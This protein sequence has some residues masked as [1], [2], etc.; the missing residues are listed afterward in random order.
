MSV[1]VTGGTGTVGL[2]IVERLAARGPVTVYASPAPPPLVAAALAAMPGEVHVVEGD[3]RD[4]DR[5]REVL[6]ERRIEA[7]VHGAAITPG[8]ERERTD[9][10]GV[11]DVNVVGAVT[12]LGAFADA[13]SGRY[14]HLGSIAAYGAAAATEPLLVEETGQERPENLYEITKLAG[15]QAVLRVAGLR[16]VDAVSLRLGDVFGRW[17][18]RSSAR[19][20]TS[21]PFQT[22]AAALEGVEAVLPRE[23]RKAWITTG[24]CAAAV[25][26]ALDAPALP[27]RVVNVSSPFTW[28]VLQWCELL[29]AEFPGFRARVDPDAATI[30]MFAD[31]APMSLER[32][33]RIGFAARED[34]PAAFAA[35]LAWAREHPEFLAR[36]P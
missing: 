26:R 22:L 35:Y 24:D 18:L 29:A 9:A 23:G 20:A 13:C 16:G 31:N 33:E 32:A 17:E 30:A 4:G 7:M 11:L 2:A 19:D 21:A 36:R 12:A 27:D 28:S 14:V 6:R 5:L 15:E 1:L 25:E 8:L 10:A 34:L 3:V